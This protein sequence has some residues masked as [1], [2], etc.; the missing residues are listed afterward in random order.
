V[1]SNSDQ[2]SQC[3]SHDYQRL[4]TNINLTFIYGS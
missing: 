4:L 3:P 1:C 2:G